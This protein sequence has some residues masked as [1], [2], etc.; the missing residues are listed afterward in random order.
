MSEQAAPLSGIDRV[1]NIPESAVGR[2]AMEGYLGAR[3]L[4]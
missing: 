2:R 4:R 3:H 1:F